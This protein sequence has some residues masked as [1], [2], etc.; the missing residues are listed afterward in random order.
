MHVFWLT[1]GVHMRPDSQEEHDALVLLLTICQ[2]GRPNSMRR[3]LRTG[4]LEQ[5]A[6][7]V[8]GDF[9]TVLVPDGPLGDLRNQ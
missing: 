9:E 8:A 2:F 7:F 1:D 5:G 4:V 6:Q 3:P